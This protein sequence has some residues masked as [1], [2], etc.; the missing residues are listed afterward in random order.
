[1]KIDNIIEGNFQERPNRFTV[2]FETDGV[3]KKAHLR[4]PGRLKELLLPEAK[5]LLRPADNVA[6][7][8]TK[9][10]VIAVE[11]EGIW[12][13]INSGFH[14][15]LA[16]EL[17]ESGVVPEFSDYTV[18]KREYTFGN[19]R[20]DFL[21]ASG[22]NVEKEEHKKSD[23]MLLEVKGCTLV[24]EGHAKFPDAPTI[25]GKRHLEELIKAKNQGMDSAVLFLIPR[26]DPQIFSPNWEMDPEFSG[27]L[28]QAKKQKVLIIAYAFSV[29]YHDHELELKPLKK[30]EIKVK[31]EI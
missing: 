9:Y 13:L 29:D 28:E 14:S 12:V 25:R 30:V 5:L 20:I 22:E 21:L 23:R 10:D 2:V 24:E 17:I 18:E 1:M 7:R 6:N 31:V 8:K 15:D 4:D 27:T 19:S 26:D 11:C 16:A 3:N